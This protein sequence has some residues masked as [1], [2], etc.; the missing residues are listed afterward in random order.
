M[1]YFV[2]LLE[3][4]IKDGE[5]SSEK[6][7][8]EVP[9]TISFV[10]SMLWLKRSQRA[11][12]LAK[13][14][15]AYLYSS[16]VHAATIN[17]LNRVGLGVSYKTLL[18]SI[19]SLNRSCTRRFQETVSHCR[20]LFCW[21]NVNFQL[22]PA[23]QRLRSSG[24]FESGTA[25]TVIELHPP[26]GSGIDDID[27]ALDL[28]QY[29][30]SVKNAADLKIED[31]MPTSEDE[32]ALRNEFVS[33][34]INVLTDHAGDVFK[35]FK[36]TNQN[37]RPLIRPLLPLRVSKVY[38]LPTLHIE[39]ASAN[40][41]A[42]V[43]EELQRT[44]QIEKSELFKRRI[45]LTTGDLLTITR[46][47]SVRDVR[48]LYMRTPVHI[49]DIHENL[50]YLVPFASLFHIRMTGA[51]AIL[52]THFG[53]P[54]VRPKDGPASLWRHNEVLKRKNIPLNQ[55]FKYRTVQDL[56]FHSLYTR[57]LDI[58][59]IESGYQSLKDFGEHLANLSHDDAWAELKRVVSDAVTRFT[60]PEEA[61]TDDV[62]RNSM[63]Y[64]RDTLLF[65]CLSLQ[66]N[67][68]IWL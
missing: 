38:P 51:A 18:G 55:A 21:D 15:T 40:G 49:K 27:N 12:L 65:R 43:I 1:P 10:G 26:P 2:S 28:D 16:G 61:D 35:E 8:E 4:F 32:K 20:S 42:T 68:A 46:L 59:R 47:L 48:T 36:K 14:F 23:E 50:S 62:L 52:H 44:T 6:K 58:V 56:V 53:K 22:E 17:V 30:A 11:N 54:N 64:I 25:A 41:N 66:L 45:L 34:T 37:L 67:A 24:S 60:T 63:L 29:L 31:I 3:A 13:G 5:H 39:Q 57:L 33:E 7:E 9:T 19:S